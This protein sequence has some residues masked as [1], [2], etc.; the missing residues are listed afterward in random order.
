MRIDGGDRN[1]L[2]EVIDAGLN[3]I[4]YSGIRPSNIFPDQIPPKRLA[5]PDA[6]DR[7][8]NIIFGPHNDPK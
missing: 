4:T 7:M 1:L 5:G 6:V 8:T 2:I 3:A